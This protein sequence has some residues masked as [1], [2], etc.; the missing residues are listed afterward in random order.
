NRAAL[1]QEIGRRIADGRGFALMFLALDGLNAVHGGFGNPAGEELLQ[2]AAGRLARAMPKAFLARWGDDEFVAIGPHGSGKATL[3]EMAQRALEAIGQP[4]AIAGHDIKLT[5]SI[6]GACSP[7]HGT[8]SQTLLRHADAA[9][10]AARQNGCNR[11]VVFHEALDT[12]SQRRA[13]LHSQLRADVERDKF[14]FLLQPKVDGAGRHLGAELLMRWSPDRIGT[15]APAEFI[16][17]AEDIGV[18]DRLGRH[19]IRSAA[20]IARELRTIDSAA[21]IAVNLSPDQLSR[22]GLV[23]MALE[24][25]RAEGADPSWLELELTESALVSDI[26]AVTR[27][28]VRLRDRGFCLALD[29]FGTGYSSLSHLR[30][31]PLHKVKVDQSFVKDLQT[32]PRSLKALEGIVALCR[33]LRITTVAEGVETSAQFE[34]LRATGIDEFQGYLFGRPMAKEAWF[35]QLRRMNRPGSAAGHGAG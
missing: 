33:T 11:P 34:S 28:L 26:G 25:C 7:E 6:G 35:E 19:A 32:D 4:C 13:R 9:M 16:P 23:D 21:T 3:G 22:P 2:L 15:V 30:Q 12:G 18:F 24:A 5:P 14:H 10:F 27:L 20:R 1:D 17:I 31:L 29:D 8:D